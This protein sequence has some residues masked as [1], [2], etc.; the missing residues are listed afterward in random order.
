MR[1]QLLISLIFPLFM[2]AC[3]D[4]EPAQTDELAF[5]RAWAQSWCER[6][7]ECALAD[8]EAKWT[9]VTECTDAKANLAEFN[10]SWG[11]LICGDFDKAAGDTCVTSVRGLTCEAWSDEDWQTECLLVYG[12]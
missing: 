4:V 7:E 5:Q 1:H 11:D 3:D 8:F 9:D 12:C 6:Q 10:G 2:A